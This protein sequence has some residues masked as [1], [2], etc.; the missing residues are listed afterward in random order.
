MSCLPFPNLEQV[1]PFGALEAACPRM[2][3]AVL[4][5]T[6]RRDVRRR[7]AQL[8][9]ILLR[10]ACPLACRPTRAWYVRGAVTRMG[11]DGIRRA[12]SPIWGEEAPSLRTIRSYLGELEAACVLIRAPGD[13]LPVLRDPEAPERRP[14]YPDTFHILRTDQEAEWW[15]SAGRLLLERNPNCRRNPDRWRMLFGDWRRR[16]AEQQLDLEFLL[17]PVRSSTG[18]GSRGKVSARRQEAQNEASVMIRQALRRPGWEPLGF[19]QELSEAGCRISGPNLARL[20]GEPERLRGAAGMLA[21][22]LARGDRIRNRAGWLVRVWKHA[23]RS[24]LA[25]AI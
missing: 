4:A 12:W 21:R 7:R 14:R 13:W 8:L 5:T 25:A 16:A 3:N 17:D 2:A 22:A 15:A 20:C 6:R 11:A 10:L 24:E 1:D 9:L 19:L 18:P 23:P